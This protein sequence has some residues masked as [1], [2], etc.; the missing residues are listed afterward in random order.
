MARRSTYRPKRTPRRKR[1]AGSSGTLGSTVLKAL[2]GYALTALKRKLGLN[3]ETKYSDSVGTTTATGTLVSRIPSPTIAQGLTVNTRQGTNIR[4]V[5]VEQRINIQAAV[6]ATLG[7]NVR[8]IT[9]RQRLN[10]G[11]ITV[12]DVLQTSTDFSSPIHNLFHEHGLTLLQD[13]TVRLGTAT[14][15]NSCITLERTF[16]LPNG[17]MTWTDA[18]TTGVPSN[19][20]RGAIQTFWM[21]DNVTTAPYFTATNRFW[22]VDN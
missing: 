9:V 5:K 22:Y 3:T 16:K 13:E 11:T 17:Q 6:A 8:I 15:D 1:A 19:L 10:D 7:C 4:I 21:V 2:K 14:A 20:V 12:A 18:D